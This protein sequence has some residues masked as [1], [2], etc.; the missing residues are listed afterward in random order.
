MR[1]AERQKLRGTRTYLE[2]GDIV[3]EV[4]SEED[5]WIIVRTKNGDKGEIPISC[6]E[7]GTLILLL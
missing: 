7:T 4:T 3:F 6:T 1:I 2:P 5:G